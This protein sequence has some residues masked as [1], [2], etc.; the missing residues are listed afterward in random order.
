MNRNNNTEKKICIIPGTFDPVTNGHID[1]VKRAAKLFDKIYVTAFVN[2]SKKNMFSPEDRREMLRLACE[3]LPDRGEGDNEKITVDVTSELLP[4]YARS[5]GANF[6]AKGVRN[7]IDYELEYQMFL[8]NRETAKNNNP[9]PGIELETIFFPSKNEFIYISS[10]FVKEM[11][12][13]N[14]DISP[15]V[16]AKVCEYI[17]NKNF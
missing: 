5:K 1:V 14:K 3:D 2:S 17:K 7:T 10:S 6:I 11:L 13:Y 12:I 4:D 16:P 9:E 15:Y 8:I